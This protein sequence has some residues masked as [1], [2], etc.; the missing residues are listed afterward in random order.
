MESSFE[1]SWNPQTNFLLM[2]PRV[3][4]V[5]AIQNPGQSWTSSVQVIPAKPS[6]LCAN[7]PLSAMLPRVYNE[8]Q[9][10][11]ETGHRNLAPVLSNSCC[12]LQETYIAAC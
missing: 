5:L 1:G 11:P 10:G 7:L 4:I 9:G 8:I 12:N 6:D 2:L 3:Q